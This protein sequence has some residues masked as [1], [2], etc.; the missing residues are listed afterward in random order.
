MKATREA[1]GANR[2]VRF[3]YGRNH[4]EEDAIF[5]PFAFWRGRGDGGRGG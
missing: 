1:A 4:R 5:L 3:G 2:C